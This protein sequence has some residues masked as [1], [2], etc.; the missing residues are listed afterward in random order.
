VTAGCHYCGTSD[1]LRPYGPSGS[2]ICFPCMKAT[3][4]REA[5][6]HNALGALIG[7]AEAASPHGVAVIGTDDGPVPLHLPTEETP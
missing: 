7:A 3:P 5:T 2:P 1:G 4:E 6:A